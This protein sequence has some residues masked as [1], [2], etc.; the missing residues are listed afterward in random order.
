MNFERM[1][2]EASR[3]IDVKAA[4]IMAGVA[5]IVGIAIVIIRHGRLG[6]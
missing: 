5:A 2:E 3:V 1:V 6:K 4:L